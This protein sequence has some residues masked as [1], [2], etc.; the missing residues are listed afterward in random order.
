MTSVTQSVTANFDS[1]FQHVTSLRNQSNYW[2]A[3]RIKKQKK[4]GAKVNDKFYAPIFF[5]IPINDTIM[6]TSAAKTNATKDL[7]RVK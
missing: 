2:V 6:G 3:V 7:I 1:L 5:A 4:R